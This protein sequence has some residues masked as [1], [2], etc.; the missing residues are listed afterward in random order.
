M[1]ERE[2][3]QFMEKQSYRKKSLIVFESFIKERLIQYPDTSASQMHDWLKEHFADFPLVSPKTVF[4][5]VI[6]GTSALPDCQN[7]Y[8]QGV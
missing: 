7:K 6:G 2:F 5:F 8:C 4:N 1:N 3:D